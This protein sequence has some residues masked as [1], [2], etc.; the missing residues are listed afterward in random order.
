M[1]RIVWSAMVCAAVMSQV[2]GAEEI[3]VEEKVQSAYELYLQDQSVTLQPKEWQLGIGLSYTHDEQYLGFVH[4]EQRSVQGAVSLGYGITDRLEL[5][6]SVPVVFTDQQA[7]DFAGTQE[8]GASEV[9]FG[10]VTLGLNAT[11]LRGQ[12]RPNVTVQTA[13]TLPTGTGPQSDLTKLSLGVTAYQDF[14][15]AFVYG[16][17][18][19]GHTFGEE[20]ESDIG[21][22]FGL[23][24][25]L[26]HRLAI[27]A[28]VEGGYRPVDTFGSKETTMLTGRATYVLG[29]YSTVQP[30]VSF[31]LT[32]SSP[33]LTLGLQ[34]TRR[35]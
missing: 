29:K 4:Q 28:E 12:G 25:S 33:D 21:Y 7:G 18:T 19:V 2:A 9:Y 17:V 10:G 15:P 3:G 30:S 24:F 34:W 27:G 14:D 8:F 11:V 35:F 32:D 22:R 31:G 23:G 26:N 5:T 6:G 13:V 1:K 20:S 16:G